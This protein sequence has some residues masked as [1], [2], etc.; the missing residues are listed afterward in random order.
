[1]LILLINLERRR[2]RLEFMR[3]Q[4]AALGLPFERIE[5][6]DCSTGDFGV[7]T[8]TITAAERACALS[9]RKAWQHFLVSG[10]QRCLI[11]E[12]DVILS[13]AL[14]PFLDNPANIPPEIELL[15]LETRLMRTRLGLPRD[16][17][18]RGFRIHRLRSTHF[19]AAAYVMSRAFADAAV[20]D[21]TDFGDPVDHVLFGTG[22]DCFYPTAAHQLRPALGIQAELVEPVANA[23]VAASDLQRFRV[24]RLPK[25]AVRLPSPKRSNLVRILREIGRVPRN[26]KAMGTS[27]HETLA[28]RSV[29]CD[30]PFAGPILPAASA[31]LSV[32]RSEQAM[33]S[34]VPAL[35]LLASD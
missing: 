10:Q 18:V 25:I 14:K 20:R 7:D 24:T 21:L 4:L 2:D 11:L 26:L 33:Q 30:V 6:I 22:E 28:T 1:M 32:H 5:A 8:P 16:S 3:A 29:W 31:A 9:H 23:T 13:P 35:R 12:D 34:E 15:H 19:G 27:V 17:G